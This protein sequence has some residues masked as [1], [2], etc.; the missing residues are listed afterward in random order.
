ML[1]LSAT[2]Q[3]SI[4]QAYTDVAAEET[5]AKL[6]ITTSGR[7]L[8]NAHR[9][10]ATMERQ[11]SKIGCQIQCI[12]N[13]A[14]G[15]AEIPPESIV[16]RLRLV[17]RRG[18][19]PHR[20][21]AFKVKMNR[22]IDRF[23][24]PFRK[25][26]KR[27]RKGS[28]IKTPGLKAGDMVRVRNR[29]EIEATLD[30]WGRLKSCMFM[31]EEMSPYCGTTQRVLRRVERFVDERDYRVKVSNGIVFLEGLY[32]QGTSDFGRCDRMCFYFWREEWLE[33][34]EEG[35]MKATDMSEE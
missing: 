23:L 26:K 7:L 4:P 15:N 19:G 2:W 32:C 31:P 27:I 30:H 13:L 25:S 29:E 5:R 3:T 12:P 33:K 6:S 8:A 22:I 17:L 21:Q 9:W 10:K 28:T 18:L 11:D 1:I 34:I 14:E 35:N 24:K 20:V 16:R